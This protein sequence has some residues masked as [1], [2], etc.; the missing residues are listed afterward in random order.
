MSASRNSSS[1]GEPRP[2]PEIDDDPVGRELVQLLGDHAHLRGPGF[3][4]HGG[5]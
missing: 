2:G 5:S 3:A 4:I 1:V